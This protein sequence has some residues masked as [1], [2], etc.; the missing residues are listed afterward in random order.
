MK[1]E[2]GATPQLDYVV[3]VGY[4]DAWVTVTE[5]GRRT[6]SIG[7]NA[8]TATITTP[9]AIANCVSRAEKVM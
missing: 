6:V 9:T 5:P 4:E 3:R 1:K 2:L 8:T 7:P